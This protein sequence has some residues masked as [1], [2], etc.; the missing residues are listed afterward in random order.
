MTRAQQL[1]PFD[2]LQL[3]AAAGDLALLRVSV[4]QG[5][6]LSQVDALM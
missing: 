1:S 2:L 5:M 3:R 6:L 4:F